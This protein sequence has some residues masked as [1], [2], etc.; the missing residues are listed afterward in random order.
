[1]APGAVRRE[2]RAGG[3]RVER[4]QRLAKP[5]GLTEQLVEALLQLFAQTV[6]HVSLLFV[7]RD[8]R[9]YTREPKH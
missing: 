1:M 5:V 7:L 8:G 9:S 3:A 4:G 6:D 2:G